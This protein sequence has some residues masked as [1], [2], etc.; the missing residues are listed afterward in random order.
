[1]LLIVPGKY[2]ALVADFWESGFQIFSVR[3][4]ERVSSTNN[5]NNNNNNNKFLI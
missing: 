4:K 2:C 1:M 3:I 5:N